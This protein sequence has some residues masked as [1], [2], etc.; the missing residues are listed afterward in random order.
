MIQRS[1]RFQTPSLW[2]T[3]KQYHNTFDTSHFINHRMNF[4]AYC[5]CP[6]L[7]ASI[8]E[9]LSHFR[10][11]SGNF[12]SFWQFYFTE[13]IILHHVNLS[14]L[15]PA[16]NLHNRP[17]KRWVSRTPMLTACNI[18]DSTVRRSL[19]LKLEYLNCSKEH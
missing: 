17:L 2:F 7:K 16:I 13:A 5:C 3:A 4:I 10:C 15:L 19:K 6:C 1:F 8:S 12:I 14:S 18:F 11:N 9:K